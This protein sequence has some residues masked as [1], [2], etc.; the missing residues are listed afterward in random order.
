M[1]FLN[2]RLQI[3]IKKK[4]TVIWPFPGV[5]FLDDFGHFFL[6]FVQIFCSFYAM[7]NTLTI[8]ISDTKSKQLLVYGFS[9]IL[10]G[11]CVFSLFHLRYFPSTPRRYFNSSRLTY[12]LRIFFHFLMFSKSSHDTCNRNCATSTS[13]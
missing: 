8:F 3:E 13:R 1:W 10:R 2:S 12:H 7:Y 5:P 6:E 11:D 9:R 4:F